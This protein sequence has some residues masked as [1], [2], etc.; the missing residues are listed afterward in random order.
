[1]ATSSTLMIIISKISLVVGILAGESGQVW[2]PLLKKVTPTG[3]NQIRPRVHELIQAS[4]H[5]RLLIIIAL[6]Q[7]I[8]NLFGALADAE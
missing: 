7:S 8:S 6:Y 3:T 1:M 5:L 2:V 4:L